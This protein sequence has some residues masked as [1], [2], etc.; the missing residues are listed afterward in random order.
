MDPTPSQTVGPF[1][2]VCLLRE[3]TIGRLAGPGAEGEPVALI[4]RVLDGDGAPVDDALIELWQTDASGVYNH[5][6]DPRYADHDPAFSGFAR[7][8]TDSDGECT[9]RTIKPGS[10]SE[11][12]H[13]NVSVFAR[14]LLKRAV[15]R[16]YFEN[17]LANAED[18]V[19]AL[20]PAERRETLLARRDAA[21][22][23]LWRFE[24]HLCGEYETVFF[25]L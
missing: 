6:D 24:I 22:P 17:E 16:I 3:Q 20:I 25:E 8:A 4:C 21:D 10:P 18:P 1:F 19:L 11:A 7:A 15:T 14:G 9:F 2:H 5:P 12:P 13:I 23:A